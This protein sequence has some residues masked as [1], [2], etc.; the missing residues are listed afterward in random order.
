MPF[1]KPAMRVSITLWWILSDSSKVSSLSSTVYGP[2]KRGKQIRKESRWR[3]RRRQR[4][5]RPQQKPTI[6]T[7]MM[8]KK[9]NTTAQKWSETLQKLSKLSYWS[10]N[11]WKRI[12]KLGEH[13]QK[14]VGAPS[15]TKCIKHQLLLTSNGM[16]QKID[17]C[18]YT[19]ACTTTNEE[20][21]IH[22]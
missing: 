21:W 12:W 20:Q 16:C 7:A 10:K 8:P 17:R 11:D 4:R 9:R 3:R 1:S 5:L 19:L 14:T 22:T 15:S 6:P 18:F 13:S 2:K